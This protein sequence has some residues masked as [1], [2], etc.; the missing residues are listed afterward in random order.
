MPA[1]IAVLLLQ[2]QVVVLL[3]CLRVGTAQ[4]LLPSDATMPSESALQ[5]LHDEAMALA[6]GIFSSDVAAELG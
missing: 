4:L 3:A 2:L 5:N 6:D 1:E